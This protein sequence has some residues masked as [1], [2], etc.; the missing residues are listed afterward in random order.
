MN[1]LLISVN[2]WFES[3]M[4]LGE[5]LVIVAV[6]RSSHASR[7]NARIAQPC[8]ARGPVSLAWCLT[9]AG[10]RYPWSCS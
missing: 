10:T 5:G 6:L 8:S 4:L 3:P 1:E 9:D 2:G 7:R